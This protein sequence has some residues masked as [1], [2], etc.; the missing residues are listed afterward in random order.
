MKQLQL[1][2]NLIHYI[3]LFWEILQLLQT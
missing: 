2:S 3:T 1:V